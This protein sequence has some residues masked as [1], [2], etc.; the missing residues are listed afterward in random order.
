[1]TRSLLAEAERDLLSID[2][3]APIEVFGYGSCLVRLDGANEMPLRAVSGNDFELGHR[4]LQ[5]ILSKTPLSGR[6]RG[7]D[8]CGGFGLAHG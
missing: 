6:Q 2:A 1:M 7:F 8:G 5:M 3:V 4:V